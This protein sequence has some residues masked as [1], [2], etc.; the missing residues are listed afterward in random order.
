MSEPTGEYAITTPHH[1]AETAATHSG[2]SG[3]SAYVAA[4][5]ARQVE[6]D[7]LSAL[8]QAAEAEH[9][10]VSDK[11]VQSLRDQLR[12]ARAEQDGRITVIKV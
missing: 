3:L 2:P 9:G 1:V 6:R 11:E 8:I 10:A 5:V 7:N 12:H 4:D